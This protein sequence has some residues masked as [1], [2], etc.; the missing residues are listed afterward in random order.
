M[1]YRASIICGDYDIELPKFYGYVKH[2][3]LYS[4]KWLIKHNKIEDSDLFYYSSVTDDIHFTADE[5]RE[6]IDLYQKDINEYNF[7][8]A[9]ISYE[10]PYIINEHYKGFNDIYSNDKDKIMYWG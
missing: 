1:G 10:K 3:D 6:F 5:F 9:N 7:L 2:S 8:S 4:I